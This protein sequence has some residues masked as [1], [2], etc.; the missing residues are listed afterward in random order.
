MSTFDFADAM[1]Q[2]SSPISSPARSMRSSPNKRPRSAVEES[3]GGNSDNIIDPLI[4]NEGPTGPTDAL[5]AAG[6][7]NLAAFAK[8][9]ATKRKL[10]P[11]QVN[12]VDTFVTVRGR[13]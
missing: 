4:R 13:L 11:Q 5:T 1:D 10:N 2:P 9:Y 7:R 6:S 12:E 3:D 8:W